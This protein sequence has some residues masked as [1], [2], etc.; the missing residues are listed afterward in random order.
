MSRTATGRLGVNG[1]S[2]ERPFFRRACEFETDE[3]DEKN[4]EIQNLT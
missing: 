1:K 3:S 4:C 2:D